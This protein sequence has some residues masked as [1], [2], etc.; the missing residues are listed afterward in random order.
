MEQEH[1]VVEKAFIFA[2]VVIEVVDVMEIAKFVSHC[3]CGV[4]QSYVVE[5][6]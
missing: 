2:T 5:S 3:L 1:W 4:V 6:R